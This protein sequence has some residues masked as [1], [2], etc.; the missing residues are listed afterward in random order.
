[1]WPLCISS[2]RL[3]FSVQD[4]TLRSVPA[5]PSRG[6]T[7]SSARAYPTL[8]GAR[9]SSLPC[10]QTFRCLSNLLQCYRDTSLILVSQALW[11]GN[12]CYSLSRR[13]PGRKGM[14]ILNRI[15]CHQTA[16]KCGAWISRPALRV[17]HRPL[18]GP[19]S[20]RSHLC[21]PWCIP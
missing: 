7:F 8:S 18:P 5:G 2:C 4:V 13:E 9:A 12:I 11:E 14:C 16:L 20:I 17:G 1:M 10:W 19:L 6:M 15:E 3:C 21:F